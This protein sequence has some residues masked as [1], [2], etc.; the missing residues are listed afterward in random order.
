MKEE[1]NKKKKRMVMVLE[2]RGDGVV[3]QSI[4]VVEVVSSEGKRSQ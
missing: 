2:I 1:E 3:S 4:M